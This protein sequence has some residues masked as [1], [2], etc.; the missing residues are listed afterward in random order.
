MGLFKK[1]FGK[2]GFFD[3]IGRGIDKKTGGLSS[4]IFKMVKKPALTVAGAALAPVTGGAS[5]VAAT[6]INKL[7]SSTVGKIGAAVFRDGIVKADKIKDTLLKVGE[8]ASDDAVNHIANAVSVG[9]HQETGLKAS[10]VPVGKA[11]PSYG[12][13][14]RLS[15][16]SSTTKPSFWDKVKANAFKAFDF[17]KEHWMWFTGAIVF[18]VLFFALKPL[19][20][21]KTYRKRRRK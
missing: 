15:P 21:K 7:S 14:S 2:K 6:A 13:K 18:V 3:K 20:S 17:V 8:A 19:F 5:L 9:V 10:V 16:S 4:K 12:S 1:V 11:S